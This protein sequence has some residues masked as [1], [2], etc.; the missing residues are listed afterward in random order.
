MI[1]LQELGDTWGQGIL[2]SS[3][4]IIPCSWC[5]GL[6]SPENSPAIWAVYSTLPGAT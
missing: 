6:S 3:F 2:P 1:F 4:Q 5:P